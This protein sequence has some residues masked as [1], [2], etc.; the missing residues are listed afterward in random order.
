[1]DIFQ[2]MQ[3]LKF[4]LKK[5]MMSN[6]RHV[7]SNLRHVMSN[8][9]P[10]V[11]VQPYSFKLRRHVGDCQFLYFRSLVGL[12]NVSFSALNFMCIQIKEDY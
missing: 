7:M 10:G 11:L 9:R 12:F 4:L 8:L 3:Y 5:H 6:S 2:E 1:M